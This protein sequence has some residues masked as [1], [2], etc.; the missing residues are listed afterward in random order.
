MKPNPYSASDISDEPNPDWVVADADERATEALCQLARVLI[1]RRTEP[2]GVWWYVKVSW[3]RQLASLIGTAV[4]IVFCLASGMDWWAMGLAC[5]WV[6]QKLR[7]LQWWRAL[8][9]QWPETVRLLDWSKI[10]RLAARGADA[11]TGPGSGRDFADNQRHEQANAG[12]T[13]SH[14]R[15]VERD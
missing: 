2:W 12:R 5:F 13:A 7:D 8:V 9:R 6:G 10:E 4:L 14:R 15:P 1:A 11:T 3:R